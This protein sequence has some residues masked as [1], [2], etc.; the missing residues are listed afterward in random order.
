MCGLSIFFHEQHK[1][2][3]SKGG[4]PEKSALSIVDMLAPGLEKLGHYK[5]AREYRG[6]EFA[7]NNKRLMLENQDPFAGKIRVT[8]DGKI[9]VIDA[10]KCMIFMKPDGSFT[11]N[12]FRHASEAFKKLCSAHEEVYDGIVH[13]RFTG[14]G[15]RETPVTD[16]QGIIKI[17]QVLPGKKA[18]AFRQSVAVL[19]ERYLDA[20]PALIQELLD[21]YRDNTGEEF[22]PLPRQQVSEAPRIKSCESNKLDMRAI[23]ESSA[24]PVPSRVYAIVNNAANKLVTG[25]E[26]TADYRKDQGLTKKSQATRDTFTDPM[27]ALTEFFHLRHQEEVLDG[28]DPEKTALVMVEALAPGLE[29]LGHYN[30]AR[31]Y[32]GPEFAANNKRLMLENQAWNRDKRIKAS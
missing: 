25:Y 9:S 23:K 8:P 13:F 29:K 26:Q 5:E 6:P 4:D 3:V 17:I 27:C 19:L 32:R 28:K 21:R 20:D 12:S 1:A 10:I 15:Q 14:Q 11:T 31:E 30:K 16:R 7:A 22:V 2:M 18:A 24:K